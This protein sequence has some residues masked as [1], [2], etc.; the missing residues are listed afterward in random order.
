VA[1]PVVAARAARLRYVS[2]R[3]PGIRRI[4]SGQGFRYRY[5]DGKRVGRAHLKRIR[6]LAI[7]PAWEHVWICKH[8]NGHIQATGRDD[9]GRKQYRYHPQWHGVRNETKYH[10]MIEFARALPAIR[11]RVARDLRLRGLSREKV[12]AAV[13]HLMEQ[14]NIR[15]GNPEYAEENQSFGLST[16]R[17]RHVHVRG[18]LLQFRFRGKS[19]KFHRVDFTSKQL[20]RIVKRCQDLPG[21]ELFQYIDDEGEIHDV[22]SDDVNG[23]LRELAGEEFTAKDFRTWSGTVLAAD[24]LRQHEGDDN[25]EPTEKDLVQAIDEVAAALGNTRAVCRKYY[26][27]TAVAAAYLDGTL[28]KWFDDKA[29]RRSKTGLS[30]QEKSVLRLLK[31]ARAANKR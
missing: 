13:V 31:R 1:D 22:T 28:A 10:R 3:K 17:H 2:D 20:A 14:T 23:Y 24:I 25:E 21:Y 5:A 16:M 30:P 11:R 4:R 8:P 26:I 12:V 29:S 7:P 6:A 18:Q 19:G 9:K 27:H 15:V